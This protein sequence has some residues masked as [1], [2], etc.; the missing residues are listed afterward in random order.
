[1]IIDELIK[2]ME[3]AHELGLTE[4][5]CEGMKFKIQYTKDKIVFSEEKTTK[6][7][8]PES[9]EAELKDLF[10]EEPILNQYTAEEILYYA[11]PHFDELQEQKDRHAKELAM[12]EELKT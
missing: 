1:M 4:L 5:E 2:I 6:E 8:S 9:I 10:K 3:K 11:T 7:E 12:H